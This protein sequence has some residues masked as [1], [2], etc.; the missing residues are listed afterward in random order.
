MNFAYLVVPGMIIGL[1]V[2]IIALTSDNPDTIFI[3][4]DKDDDY[5]DWGW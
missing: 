2:L 3:Q 4:K 1:I 5:I